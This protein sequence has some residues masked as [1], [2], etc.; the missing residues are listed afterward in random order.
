MGMKNAQQH[1]EDLK[2][3][4]DIAHEVVINEAINFIRLQDE[5]LREA[6]DT[7]Q[8]QFSIMFQYKKEIN[9]LKKKLKNEK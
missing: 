9:N 8:K 4:N 5:R 7:M 6:H 2:Q 3:Y 1:I